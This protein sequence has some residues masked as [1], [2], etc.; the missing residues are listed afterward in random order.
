MEEDKKIEVG[1]CDICKKE[2]ELSVKTYHYWARC[3]CCPTHHVE[4]VRHCKECTPEEPET[5]TVLVESK[6]LDLWG[7]L[8]DRHLQT[9]TVDEG[10][11]KVIQSLKVGDKIYFRK[12][13]RGYEIK[14][15]DCSYLIATKQ[16]VKGVWYCIIDK[17]E[18]VS[19]THNLVFNIYDFEDPEDIKE[20]LK[21]LHCDLEISH[22][23]RC[24]V[25]GLITRY[26]LKGEKEIRPICD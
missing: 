7:I 16:T 13:R 6:R 4:K 8:H 9:K 3:R 10:I 21:D 25:E 22:R 26:K 5:T 15:A 24:D 20:C 2:S 23:R 1:V 19:G 18:L 11:Q 14:A 12:E 17:K